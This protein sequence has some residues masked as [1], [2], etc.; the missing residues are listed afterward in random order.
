[1]A[2]LTVLDRQSNSAATDFGDHSRRDQNREALDGI[3]ATNTVTRDEGALIS[4]I[5]PFQRFLV[6]SVGRRPRTPS[7]KAAAVTLP[8]S[9]DLQREPCC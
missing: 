6:L 3:R 8:T 2:A 9:P 7:R 4:R 5:R 1:M